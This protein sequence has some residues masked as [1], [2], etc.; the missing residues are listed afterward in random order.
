[1]G[2]CGC[3]EEVGLGQQ[4]LEDLFQE[5]FKLHDLD[6]NGAMEENE[7]IRLNE[8]IAVL[9]HGPDADLCDVR[10]R[11]RELFRTRLDPKGDGIVNYEAF[12]KYAREVLESLD[13]DVEAQEMILEQFVAEARSARQAF[14][15]ALAEAAPANGAA[16]GLALL[17]VLGAAG[18]EGDSGADGRPG[19]AA[20]D[21]E[22]D[23]WDQAYL[24]MT[25][26]Y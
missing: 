16:G 26:T 18:V 10:L 14:D 23:P 13:P 6:G 21:A 19:T 11:Y 25:A 8:Q 15:W 5:L 9:H 20:E 4:R 1:M 7:L 24:H 17:P 12:Q 3:G 2:H 22:V